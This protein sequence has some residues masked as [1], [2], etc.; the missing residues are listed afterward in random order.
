[1]KKFRYIPVI[2]LLLQPVI[3]SASPNNSVSEAQSTQSVV[4]DALANSEAASLPRPHTPNADKNPNIPQCH[5][6]EMT[7]EE[8]AKLW[9]TLSPRHRD[10]HWRLMSLKERTELRN[11]L[12]KQERRKLR[13]RFVMSAENC[14]DPCPQPDRP[15]VLYKRLSKEELA[16][17]RDQV[18]SA[19]KQIVLSNM[20]KTPAQIEYEDAF[21]THLAEQKDLSH[22]MLIITIQ[23]DAIAPAPA[24]SSASAQTPSHTAAQ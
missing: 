10:Y 8:R 9:P 2:F 16:Q 22:R 21:L 23:E 3:G 1:M 4:V 6:M 24:P 13:E 12:P 7:T 18:R 17:L 15:Y 20:L 14:P 5:W 19:H 11:L